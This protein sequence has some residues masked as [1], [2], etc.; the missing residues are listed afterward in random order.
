MTQLHPAFDW[1]EVAR[2]VLI[3][4]RI[5]DLEEQELLSAGEVMYQFSA[6]GH[7]LGQVLISQLL[8]HS[9]D[10]VGAYYRSRPLML[11]LGLSIEEALASDMARSGSLSA[12]RDVGVVFNMPRRNKAT[13][14]PLAGDVG[15]QYTPAAGWAQ[16]ILY[17]IEQLGEKRH[18][19]SIVVVFGGDGSV[20]SNGFWSSI[21]MATTLK[22][23]MLF[24]VEDNGFAISVNNDLQTPG[25]NIAANLASFHNLEIWDGSG[26]QP[27]ETAQLVVTA[28][29]YMRAGKGPA[30]LRLVVPR[31]SGH[32]SADNQA[33]KSED[34]RLREKRADP[35]PRVRDALVPGMMEADEWEALIDEVE[36]RVL[37]ANQQALAQALPGVGGVG[38]FIFSDPDQPQSVG[39]LVAE[40][41]KLPATVG[42]SAPSGRRLNMVEAIRQTLDNELAINPRCLVIGED[43]GEKGGVHTATMGLMTRHGRGR[44]VDTSLS[45]EGIIGRAVGMALAGLMPVP[46]IQFRKYADPAT[47]QLNN[48]GTIRWRTANQFAAPLVVRIA[49]GYGRKVGDPWHSVTSE[50][51]FAH[52]VG[53]QVVIPS[54]AE[55]AVGLLRTAL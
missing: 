46:E 43:V 19:G 40:R 4:R 11:G 23:P 13:V 2:L 10:A 17:R 30:L 50:V 3:S 45:E 53:W 54:N 35:I 12:G 49:G 20:A 42:Q 15:S 24:V 37:E 47:E 39:G 14:L 55:D 26:T 22:L 6:G 44:V 18:K 1:H 5:D 28:M 33:Y 29:E 38:K 9:M 8:G 25:G 36:D 52:A 27:H 48:C 41:I 51:I 7:E 34:T 31:L 16:S 32:S 21:T